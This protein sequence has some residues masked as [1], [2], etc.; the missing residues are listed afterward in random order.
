M[1]TVADKS[2]KPK[3]R[4]L[5][6]NWNDMSIREKDRQMEQFIGNSSQSTDSNSE[7]M[8]EAISLTEIGSTS[9]GKE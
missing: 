4:N 8:G 2:V 7:V 3:S 5:S 9:S 1:N 6:I